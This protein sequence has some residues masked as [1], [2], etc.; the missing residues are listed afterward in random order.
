MTRHSCHTPCSATCLGTLQVRK[1]WCQQR[2]GQQV[3]QG[4][5]QHCSSIQMYISAGGACS[6]MPD[7]SRGTTGS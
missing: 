4:E 5:A 3:P 7:F 6:A 2:R 1:R